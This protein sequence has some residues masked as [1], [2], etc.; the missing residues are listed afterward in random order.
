MNANTKVERLLPSL[1]AFL[2]A[3]PS[4]SSTVATAAASSTLNA[5]AAHHPNSAFARNAHDGVFSAQV[6]ADSYARWRRCILVWR[7]VVGNDALFLTLLLH[8]GCLWSPDYAAI[9]AARH[10]LAKTS[11]QVTTQNDANND[12]NEHGA[13]SSCSTTQQQQQQ[14]ADGGTSSSKR[15]GKRGFQPA[16]EL[17][18][19]AARTAAV[20]AAAA[21]AHQ[22]LMN[23]CPAS[24]WALHVLHFLCVEEIYTIPSSPGLDSNVAARRAAGARKQDEDSGGSGGDDD[25]DDDVNS[26]DSASAAGEDSENGA[27][28]SSD[29]SGDDTSSDGGSNNSGSSVTIHRSSGGQRKMR[30]RK[31]VP[32]H[33]TK[34]TADESAKRSSQRSSG[35]KRVKFE[36]ETTAAFSPS[37]PASPTSTTTAAAGAAP[38]QLAASSALLPRMSTKYRS[39]KKELEHNLEFSLAALRQEQAA[40]EGDPSWQTRG[41]S[42][43][44]EDRHRSPTTVFPTQDA[45]ASP[46]KQSL[47]SARAHASLLRATVSL[48]SE[49]EPLVQEVAAAL[50]EDWLE[51]LTPTHTTRFLSAMS[52]GSPPAA[53]LDGANAGNM[54]SLFSSDHETTYQ[55]QQREARHYWLSCLLKLV[56]FLD[57]VH[58][59]LREENPHLSAVMARQGITPQA[60]EDIFTKSLPAIFNCVLVEEVLPPLSSSSSFSLTS[61]YAATRL[62]MPPPVLLLPFHLLARGS[63]FGVWVPAAGAPGEARAASANASAASLDDAAAVATAAA[64]SSASAARVQ[65]RY[66]S[67]MVDSYGLQLETRTR[68]PWQE[69]HRDTVTK[70]MEHDDASPLS[71]PSPKAEPRMDKS[72]SGDDFT[73]SRLIFGLRS[74]EPEVLLDE[75]C[76]PWVHA[77]LPTRNSQRTCGDSKASGSSS[78]SSSS[79]H[80]ASSAAFTAGA[81][82]RDARDGDA[83]AP[84]RVWRCTDAA[85]AGC[86]RMEL[87]VARTLLMLP[88]PAQSALDSTSADPP[89][90]DYATRAA[91]NNSNNNGKAAGT[92]AVPEKTT[93]VDGKSAGPTQ[94]ERPRRRVVGARG[95]YGR[96]ALSPDEAAVRRRHPQLFR[97]LQPL[98][99]SG[100]S[101]RATSPQL[102]SRFSDG[103]GLSSSSSSSGG[104]GESTQLVLLYGVARG[105]EATALRHMG[106]TVRTGTHHGLGRSGGPAGGSA[107]ADDSADQEDAH[108]SAMASPSYS[109]S[110]PTDGRNSSGCRSTSGRGGGS[111]GGSGRLTLARDAL[112]T[113]LEGLY[114][115]ARRILALKG[116]YATAG[117]AASSTS[118]GT[119]NSGEGRGKGTLHYTSSTSVAAATK[120]ERGRRPGGKGGD[121]QRYGKGAVAGAEGEQAMGTERRCVV[122]QDTRSVAIVTPVQEREAL[123][124]VAATLVL[125]AILLSHQL[126]DELLEQSTVVLWTTE[127]ASYVLDVSL[128]LSR[129]VPRLM[130]A[131][132]FALALLPRPA[133]SLLLMVGLVATLVTR[134]VQ[135]ADVKGSRPGAPTSPSHAPAAAATSQPWHPWWTVFRGSVLRDATLP[136]CLY[137]GVWAL[138]A[139]A[140][141]AVALAAAQARR[142]SSAHLHTRASRKNERVDE[143]EGD[144]RGR[145]AG[146]KAEGESGG[147]TARE[148][149]ADASSAPPSSLVVS[150]HDR[151][152][153]TT[154]GGGRLGGRER[155][156][157]L[158]HVPESSKSSGN[159]AETRPNQRASLTV[160]AVPGGESGRNSLRDS[161][162]PPPQQQQQHRHHLRLFPTSSASPPACAP[163]WMCGPAVLDQA[164][165]TGNAAS[166]NPAPP[167]ACSQWLRVVSGE[168]LFFLLETQQ[169]QQQRQ[170]QQP[171]VDAALIEKVGPG[172]SP[173]AWRAP[174]RV[175]ETRSSTAAASALWLSLEATCLQWPS[176]ERQE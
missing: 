41:G 142:A 173:A 6:L 130:H 152:A 53:A 141:E 36:D 75:R 33:R 136:S 72:S 149:V 68:S 129:P 28:T 109:T 165:W 121:S 125:T 99:T 171:V 20:Q 12:N 21:E 38:R 27:G 31:R 144:H 17:A 43:R 135:H 57:G 126:M 66:L 59:A 124:T 156:K 52:T 79:A 37:L 104:G 138:V 89:S 85:T 74:T 143:A 133:Q 56:A 111:K 160:G 162:H 42:P 146:V 157:R 147:G 77:L 44:D 132:G 7:R 116:L 25:D 145:D 101:R 105:Q 55:Q 158:L 29:S 90:A 69:E 3:D 93:L 32:T 140:E 23:A 30:K 92:T 95:H 103:G 148:M 151:S 71:P 78:S 118:S 15:R 24:M 107:A 1:Y 63:R 16:A 159:D 172:R 50:V 176:T 164:S 134:E 86:P 39:S 113:T 96:A 98:L 2:S 91:S 54:K 22:R 122:G 48:V 166:C 155:G 137:S 114:L 13:S 170:Q 117:V 9:H 80:N 131:D 119:N 65:G 49:E 62:W 153:S 73:C 8:A 97:A 14:L 87:Y 106:F 154:S 102:K 81:A 18:A 82:E 120:D 70:S 47:S 161:A 169:Q 51:L 167:F 110:L 26:K 61:P 123:G 168:E 128:W 115:M 10:T 34:N 174:Y 163:R 64:A 112:G 100:N 139:K 45:P 150:T 76:R 46:A 127:L 19:H 4:L 60:S 5:T 67:F 58:S 88:I 40:R 35:R 108:A 175:P 83:Q 11:A 84:L 94:L